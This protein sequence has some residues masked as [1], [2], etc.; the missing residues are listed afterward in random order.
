MHFYLSFAERCSQGSKRQQVSIYSENPQI[1]RL[2]GPTWDPPGS[3]RPPMAPCWPHEPCYQGACH[4]AGARPLSE[5]TVA[6]RGYSYMCSMGQLLIECT[7]YVPVMCPGA[8]FYQCD[9]NSIAKWISND[10]RA[11]MWDEITY[12][13]TNFN[14]CKVWE[15]INNST[16]RCI[17]D[18]NTDPG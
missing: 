9:L 7:F 10:P 12:A 15:W 3:C 5:P 8:P 18:A 17:M 4:G 1:A 11:K 14:V 13:F 2:M 6:V 16:Q